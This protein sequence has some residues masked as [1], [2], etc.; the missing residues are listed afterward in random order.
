MFVQRLNQRVNRFAWFPLDIRLFNARVSKSLSWNTISPM[1]W[2]F[3]EIFYRK[4]EARFVQRS[5]NT[6]TRVSGIR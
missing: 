3:I 1:I 4:Y 6:A 2:N 5:N